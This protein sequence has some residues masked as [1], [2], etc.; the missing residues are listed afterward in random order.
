M[1]EK[2]FIQSI[3]ID[4]PIAIA[5]LGGS[6]APQD[7]YEWARSANPRTEGDTVIVPAWSLNRLPDGSVEPIMPVG[8]RFAACGSTARAPASP[9]AAACVPTASS[10]HYAS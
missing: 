3:F 10:A 6:P 9:T 4:P 5:R 7:A 2:T 1:A 8:I